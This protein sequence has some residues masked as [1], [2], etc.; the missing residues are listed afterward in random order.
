[1]GKKKS[2]YS[3]NEFPLEGAKIR[4]GKIDMQKMLKKCTKNEEV[5]HLIFEIENLI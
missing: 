1:M 2:K 3:I 5:S 4:T